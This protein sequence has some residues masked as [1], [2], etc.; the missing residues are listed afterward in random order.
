MTKND[1]ESNAAVTEADKEEQPDHIYYIDGSF[2]VRVDRD[3]II[4]P[5]TA[6]PPLPSD[7]TPQ[8]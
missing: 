5:A 4:I 8:K 3:P 1:P 6:W 2:L 7:C